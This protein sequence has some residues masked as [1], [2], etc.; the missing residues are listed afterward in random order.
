MEKKLWI[1]ETARKMAQEMGLI[2][3]TRTELCGRVGISDGS[4]TDIMDESFTDM[5]DRLL[6]DGELPIGESVDR[7]RVNPLLRRSHVLN[8]AIELAKEKGY[9]SI[10]RK[11]IA[12][13]AEIT[14]ALLSHYFDSIE[15][16]R[17]TV[18]KIAIRRK[19]LEIVAQGLV[20][21]D[22]E[23]IQAPRDLKYAAVAYLAEL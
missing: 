19:V 4:F 12:E 11:E 15:S 13:A 17:A 7:K 10:T 2:N 23:A 3:I 8:K 21:N 20:N 5:M 9:N 16:L 1:E 22:P 18:L 6:E 14:P